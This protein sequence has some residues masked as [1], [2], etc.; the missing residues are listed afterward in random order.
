[1]L[2]TTFDPPSLPIIRIPKDIRHWGF[3]WNTHLR[4]LQIKNFHWFGRGRLSQVEWHPGVV[5]FEQLG[6][7]SDVNVVVVVKVTPPTIKRSK[8]FNSQIKPKNCESK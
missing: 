4:R 7:A 8:H 1:M 6:E 2:L 5:R 3:C